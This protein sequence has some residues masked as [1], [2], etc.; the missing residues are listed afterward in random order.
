M[1]GL[2]IEDATCC[3]FAWSDSIN[4]AGA[5]E[6]SSRR[7]HRGPMSRKNWR[8]AIPVEAEGSHRKEVKIYLVILCW[9]LRCRG[10]SHSDGFVCWT[11]ATSTA[12]Q[13]IR[14][15]AFVG[16]PAWQRIRRMAAATWWELCHT[17]L[18]WSSHLKTNIEA[19]ARSRLACKAKTSQARFVFECRQSQEGQGSCHG[20]EW[21]AE[22]VQSS[23]WGRSASCKR[24]FLQD[25][26][27]T[28]STKEQELLQ[29]TIQVL[30][31]EHVFQKLV[32]KY[33]LMRKDI[34]KMLSEG[35]FVTPPW[36]QRLLKFNSIVPQLCQSAP[37][38]F[39]SIWC[40]VLI[41]FQTATVDP[42]DRRWWRTIF[43]FLFWKKRC[44]G[45]FLVNLLLPCAFP[46]PSRRLEDWTTEGI[47]VPSLKP[48]CL[49]QVRVIHSASFKDKAIRAVCLNMCGENQQL[50]AQ[51][52]LLPSF[53]MECFPLEVRNIW[54]PSL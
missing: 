47:K 11:P 20:A 49:M 50:S 54:S 31:E 17:C 38:G 33:H 37:S 32:S 26:M 41:Q 13:S 28:S 46:N 29:D 52:W 23:W 44:E 39:I 51:D 6:N 24:K 1:A 12:T 15:R 42:D 21:L 35:A 7:Q 40:W 27:R 5:A 25:K 16:V 3:S 19:L 34:R 18:Q 48:P 53:S 36:C 43:R 10:F 9:F 4:E 2:W 30:R 45:C 8:A 14:P 22:E